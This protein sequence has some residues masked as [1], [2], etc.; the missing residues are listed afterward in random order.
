M[1]RASVS[2]PLYTGGRVSAAMRA[3]EWGLRSARL[4][5]SDTEVQLT[6]AVA[7]AYDDV[8]LARALDAVTRRSIQVLEEAVRVAEEHYE[9]GSVAW[10]D[11]LRAR[12]RLASARS[13]RRG[14]ETAIATA[15]ERLAAIA[16]VDPE[17]APPVSG[18]LDYAG[19]E[20]DGEALLE[21][22]RSARPDVR[23]LRAAAGAERAR[24]RAATAERWPMVSLNATGLGTNPEILT[25]R[26]RWSWKLLAVLNVAWP[27][28][29]SGESAARARTANAA[30][31]RAE[32]RATATVDAAAAAVRIALRE[33]G[34]AEEDVRAGRENVERAEQALAISQERYADGVGIQLEVL[35]AEADL[36][37]AGGD[38]LRAIHAHRVAL[39]QLRRASGLPADAPLVDLEWGDRKEGES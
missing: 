9:A 3:A 27:I 39:I 38:V 36:T 13:G 18:S 21:R 12:T 10:L 25:G 28:F 11:V 30:A 29:D 14:T 33:L 20:I 32:A 4:V 5:E 34:R 8:L 2:Q 31:E 24:A 6:A 17:R 37:R 23:A 7:Q 26:D 22:A 19:T 16:G 35:E 1:A 15:R